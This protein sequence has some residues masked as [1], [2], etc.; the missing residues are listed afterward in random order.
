MPAGL[1]RVTTR[2]RALSMPQRRR[3]SGSRAVA[4][5]DRLAGPSLA[6]HEHRIL[7]RSRDSSRYGA[8]AS[9][10]PSGRPGRSRRGS[11]GPSRAPAA[12]RP[13]PR[14]GAIRAA[15]EGSAPMRARPGWRS[16]IPSRRRA[17]AARSARARARRRRRRRGSRRRTRRPGRAGAH[18]RTRPGGRGG[19]AAPRATITAVLTAIR[20]TTPAR[21]APGVASELRHVEAHADGDEEDAEQQALERAR[22]SPRPRAGTR[23]RPAAGRR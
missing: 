8:P 1:S 3:N 17:R 4:E 23:S 19:R 9:R 12:A 22:S 6:A 21:I 16:S 10:R 11:R 2:A 18:S 5:I 20:P 13:A 7:R 14:P 15:G